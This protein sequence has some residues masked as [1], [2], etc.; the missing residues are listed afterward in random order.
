MSRILHHS[1]LWQFRHN[2]T[3]SLPS[4]RF[5][6]NTI[7]KYSHGSLPSI[8]N[9]L[10]LG[11]VPLVV[12]GIVRF[13]NLAA[14][15]LLSRRQESIF[16]QPFVLDN[17]KKVHLLV[18]FQS[19]IDGLQVFRQLLFQDSSL[20][21]VGSIHL[22]IFGQLHDGMRLRIGRPTDTGELHQGMID[23]FVFNRSRCHVLSFTSL[24][25]L[26][27]ASS[28]LETCNV[29]KKRMCE[30]HVVVIAVPF[31]DLKKWLPLQIGYTYDLL[32]QSLHDRQS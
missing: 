15:N 23:K 18:L 8:P 27:G 19:A 6:P 17:D 9:D 16:R 12:V 4:V 25:E 20:V 3:F 14:N 2:S 22:G 10:I 13:F 26:L 5:L 32:H 29:E 30:C 24:E 31:A 11:S 7:R 1:Q 21:G 28:N